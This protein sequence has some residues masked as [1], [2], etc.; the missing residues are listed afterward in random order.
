MSLSKEIAEM[1][2]ELLSD[3]GTTEIRRND[4]A[5]QFG[6]VPSQINY[7]LASRFTPEHGYIVESRRG[8]GGY[9][10]ITRASYNLDTLKMHLIN[11]IGEKID[12]K[13]CRAHLLN[14][15]DRGLLSE[16]QVVLMLAATSGYT[17]RDIQPEL[18]DKLRASVLKQML[19]STMK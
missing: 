7:V 5:E 1:I 9:I 17:Y 10:K 14:L 11:S 2:V 3:S 8:G 4:L 6:C 16:Q 12:E 15:H 13:T 19:I 18:R